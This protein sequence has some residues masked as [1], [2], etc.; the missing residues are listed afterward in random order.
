MNS[1]TGRAGAKALDPAV[2]AVIDQRNAERAAIYALVATRKVF[3]VRYSPEHFR[4]LFNL[5]R[6]RVPGGREYRLYVDPRR[7]A[8]AIEGNYTDADIAQ[9][10]AVVNEYEAPFQEEAEQRNVLEPVQN[11]FSPVGRNSNTKRS[12]RQRHYRGSR[13]R[14]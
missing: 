13:R 1:M 6:Q 2:Q 7:Q 3:D 11:N 4:G 10:L 9:L 14:M 12:I 5:F 8:L